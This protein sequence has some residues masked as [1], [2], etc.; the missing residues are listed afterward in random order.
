[1]NERN[2]Q[3]TDDRLEKALAAL[4]AAE[5]NSGPPA[6]V[7]A[8]TIERLQSLD[9]GPNL[10]RLPERKPRRFGTLQYAG[11]AAVLTM[12]LVIWGFERNAGPSFAQVIERIQKAKAVRFDLKQKLGSQPEISSRM[13]LQGQSVRYEI[14]DIL[15]LI[16]DL[17][18]SRACKLDDASQGC[19]QAR[20]GLGDS[21]HAS[22][23]RL[24]GCGF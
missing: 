2:E 11:I 24:I 18:Q 23:T 17:R 10:V 5:E 8:A 12:A 15:V 16:M 3:P 9:E 20:F 21:G 1:M 22:G 13:F 19:P 14:Q 7:V 6:H 4:R